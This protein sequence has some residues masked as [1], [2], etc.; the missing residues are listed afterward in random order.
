MPVQRDSNIE[1]VARVVLDLLALF[2]AANLAFDLRY[3]VDWQGLLGDVVKEG[4]APWGA[5]YRALPYM[6]SIM[7][8]HRRM[9]T[10]PLGSF[11]KKV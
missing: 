4:T 7:S 8:L 11:D 5:L 9:T 2:F 3:Y 1:Q 6:R 10:L